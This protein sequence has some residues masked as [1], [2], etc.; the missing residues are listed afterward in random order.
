MARQPTTPPAKTPS[1]ETLP[2]GAGD[3]H[4]MLADFAENPPAEA[5]QGYYSFT[6]R[7][8]WHGVETGLEDGTYAAGEW[9]IVIS[10]GLPIDAVRRDH[11]LHLERL[12]KAAPDA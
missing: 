8:R 1:A 3:P 2:T 12:P 5:A 11:P 10:G 7:D 4:P 9:E 6:C